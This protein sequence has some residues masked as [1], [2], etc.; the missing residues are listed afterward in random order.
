M[1]ARRTV[2]QTVR[3]MARMVTL[4]A[5][6]AAAA[7][8]T[9]AAALS[10][11]ADPSAEALRLLQAEDWAAAARAFEALCRARPDD[12]LSWLRLG[13]ALHGQGQ[14]AKAAEA[15]ERAEKLGGPLPQAQVRVAK[16]AAR[17][18]EPD[19]AFGALQRAVAGGFSNGAL[20]ASD[21]D[22]AL[23][24]K[25]AR[26]AE[27]ATAVDRNARP[28]HYVPEFRQFDFWVGEWDVRQNGAPTTTPAPSSRIEI[29]ESEC[30]VLE[31]YTTPGP[32]SGRSFNVYDRE[33]RHWR[34]V[35]VDTQGRMT[36]YVGVLRD[37][38]LY[39]TAEGVV[40][41]GSPGLAK[42]KMT[43]FDEGPN[44]VRQLVEQSVDEGAHWQT[45][46]DGIYT[47][48]GSAGK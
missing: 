40:V 35:Y 1:I 28:C 10:T 11:P 36:D 30:V 42:V 47:R 39:F 41:P 43:F 20:L 33:R 32:Y 26:F 24:A 17:L 37:G 6:G 21:P 12:G 22:L 7:P 44:R 8:V 25:D 9:R 34:Q 38:N 4:V 2:R 16:S 13:M 31:T 15:S 48:K 46:F 14:F 27:T 29:I 45:V 23:L 5:L 3:N 19:R 18:G